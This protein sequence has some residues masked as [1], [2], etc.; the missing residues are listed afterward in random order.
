M[1]KFFIGMVSLLLLLSTIVLGNNQW[2]SVITPTFE[3]GLYGVSFASK[4]V[5]CAVGMSG[6]ILT[7][8]D[9]GKTWTDVSGITTK[10]LKSVTFTDEKNGWIAGSGGTLLRTTDG[11]KTWAPVGN[12]T[13][14][15]NFTKVFF[16][17]ASHGWLVGRSGTFYRT[18]DGGTNWVKAS[19]MGGITEDIN[20]ISFFDANNGVMATKY[21]LAATTDG[22]DHWTK[23]ALDFGGNSYTRNDF[24]AIFMVSPTVAYATGWGSMAA[25]LQPTLLLKTTDGG[26]S[27]VFLNQTN[28]TYCYGYDIYFSDENNGWIV[29]GGAGYG[30]LILK[31]T[32][33]GKTF[34]QQPIFTGNTLYSI[35]VV[36]GHIW[37]AGS[38][39]ELAGSDDG[40]QTWTRAYKIPYIVNYYAVA[41]PDSQSVF[42]A[43]W[44]GGL[45]QSTN[46]GKDWEFRYVSENNRATRIQ[47]LFFLNAKL[48]WSCGGYASIAR[49]SD[50]GATWEGL[51]ISNNVKSS[52]YGIFF[53]DANTGFVCGK[54][55]RGHDIIEYTQDG[56]SNWN[57]VLEDS[58]HKPI[59]D[60]WF[61]D[62]THGVAVG[63]DSSIL[64][65]ADGGMSWTKAQ[66]DFPDKVDFESVC[67]ASPQNGWVVGKAAK[68]KKSAVL[69]SSDGGA[70]WT[71][72]D[73]N[74]SL[75]LYKV[76]F[77][78][79]T[80]GWIVGEGGAVFETTDGGKTWN[81][82]DVENSSDLKSVAQA[83]DGAPWIVGY[84][85]TV[86]TRPLNTSVKM[87]NLYAR[88][89]VFQLHQ[90]Y[91]NPFNPVTTISFELARKSRVKLSVFD[92]NG[93]KIQTL[94]NGTESAGT[95]FV[96]WN[97][98]NLPSG[99]YFYRLQ[100]GHFSAM[101]KLLLLK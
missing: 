31:T 73:L 55:S 24:K 53:Q 70:K 36:E 27:W 33:G 34:T 81:P 94:I 101:K 90:N 30:S 83:S 84:K 96:R 85:S 62:K 8:T 72:V 39:G 71:T 14:S 99:V 86:L 93:G 11:C 67:F 13:S 69:H 64:Y 51:N 22:G 59:Y 100:T 74:T 49:T 20:A 98:A 18:T 28:P 45:L 3:T 92:L 58:T 43:G 48:G 77:Q 47:D 2:M 15:D 19:D 79:A 41:T 9:G 7:T 44:N 46:G 25:G 21:F 42:A 60:I 82:V 17:D 75:Y 16:L 4:D 95:H 65:T 12:F 5:G 10:T 52:W 1:K 78:N 38:Y 54:D 76:R 29:G 91:P 23:G 26:K 35:D 61:S 50:G 40:G 32:D 57:A 97:A 88:P 87:D 37:V 68:G 80:H 56:G 6:T 89:R 63:G 66:H